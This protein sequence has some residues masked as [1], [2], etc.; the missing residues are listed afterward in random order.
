MNKTW[1]GQ[2]ETFHIIIPQAINKSLCR[3]MPKVYDISGR[4][5]SHWGLLG[6]QDSPSKRKGYEWSQTPGQF[7]RSWYFGDSNGILGSTEPASKRS[8]S[9]GR[10]NEAGIDERVRVRPSTGKDM[11]RPSI[12]NWELEA[13]SAIL[14]NRW[15]S[16][17][18]SWWGLPTAAMHTTVS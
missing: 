6:R 3:Q 11:G 13:R 9:H 15:R 17:I 1:P 8:H 7:G 12:P 16:P 18:F 4:Y 10:R 5:H 2:N 14:Q